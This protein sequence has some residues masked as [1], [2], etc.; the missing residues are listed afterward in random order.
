MSEIKSPYTRYATENDLEKI[1]SH[2]KTYNNLDQIG[3][4]NDDMSAT[5]FLTNIKTIN[6]ALGDGDSILYLT[7]T[8]ADNLH[9]SAVD[10]LSSDTDKELGFIV[11]NKCRFVAINQSGPHAAYSDNG[12][13]WIPTSSLP[14]SPSYEIRWSS[15][16]YGNDK[17]VAVGTSYDTHITY[18]A[19][20]EDGINWTETKLC[21]G[22]D[23]FARLAYGNGR[24]VFVSYEVG[25]SEDGINWNMGTQP[26]QPSS[27]N[28]YWKSVTYGNG[29]F[30]AVKDDGKSIYSEDGINWLN[31]TIPNY[32]WALVSYGN[33]KFVAISADGKSAYSED[34]I[35]WMEG[36]LPVNHGW[37][38]AIAYGN[39]TFIATLGEYP[40]SFDYYLY[41]NDGINWNIGTLPSSD[42]WRGITY[43]NGKF[44]ATR[45]YDPAFAYSTDGINW[46]IV[47]IPNQSEWW[48]NP[49]AITCN[50]STIKQYAS[51]PLSLKISRTGDIHNTVTIEAIYNADNESKYIYSCNYYNDTIS[52]FTNEEITTI[53]Q[54]DKTLSSLT[55]SK[56][57][58]EP[59]PI[60]VATV[61]GQT[62]FT[63]NYD[64]FDAENDTLLVQSGITMLYPNVD[65]T[66]SG[67]TVT[68]TEGV[69]LGRTIGMYMMKIVQVP[70]SN[71]IISYGTVDLE[72]GITP[73][74]EGHIHFVYEQG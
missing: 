73:L 25:Y 52:N 10:K 23:E 48:W 42:W 39:G 7:T 43:G 74:A 26:T 20:S 62:Q 57:I 67:N 59:L 49:Q 51:S 31:G 32:R 47:E 16:T 60:Q 66:V 17:F 41:S 65:F 11:E 21:D 1:Q 45:N 19:Y 30:V 37:W 38:Q 24:F 29:K 15:I 68:L 50:P 3:L 63:V 71:N 70:M 35:T 55:Q 6:T 28:D 61:E 8:N 56:T 18:I 9:L 14:S 53:K 44:V 34:G 12:I 58:F 69:P 40:E 36:T 22:T 5:D 72:P 13:D 46:E 64:T 4:S 2:I 54:I 33:G 27:I